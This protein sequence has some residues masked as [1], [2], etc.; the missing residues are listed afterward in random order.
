MCNKMGNTHSS[1]AANTHA[2]GAG[3]TANKATHTEKKL[4]AGG[5]V[6]Y[7]C[8]HPDADA[9]AVAVGLTIC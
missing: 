1:T 5:S 3:P 2:G 8:P 7:L 6:F 4:Q 9:D